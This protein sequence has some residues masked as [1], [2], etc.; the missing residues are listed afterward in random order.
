MFRCTAVTP[1]KIIFEKDVKSVI[2]P[3]LL[4]YLGI[5]TDHAPLITPL[6]PGRLE[7]KDSTGGEYIFF[8]SGGFLEVSGNVCTILADA[9]EKPSEIDVARAQAAEKRAR[10]RLKNRNSPDLDVERAEAALQRAL[11]RQKISSASASS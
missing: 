4:G 1:E 3:G 6:V 5:L 9:I 2:A 8:L 10:D 7:L 11:W